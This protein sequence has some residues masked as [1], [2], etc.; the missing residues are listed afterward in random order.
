MSPARLSALSVIVYSE[1]ITMSGLAA[2]EQVRLPT[3]S[4]L[5][6][7]M[8]HDGLVQRLSQSADARVVT[9]TPTAKG[10]EALR[11]GRR[12]RLTDL[13]SRLETCST[14]ELADIQRATTVLERLFG[15]HA[16]RIED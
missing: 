10:R 8:E 16:T 9:V 13:E 1:Q 3:M 2:A 14:Q 15:H 6:A 12:L 4:R 5:I 7:G 11:R